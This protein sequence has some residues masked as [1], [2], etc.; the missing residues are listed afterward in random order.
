M[1]SKKEN[2]DRANILPRFLIGRDQ[3][4]F[5]MQRFRISAYL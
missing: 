2:D 1:M 3:Y 4:L 5:D